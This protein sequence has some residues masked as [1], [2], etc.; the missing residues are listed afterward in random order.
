MVVKSVQVESSLKRRGNLRKGGS[1]EREREIRM[2]T[3]KE[4]SVGG[5]LPL[6]TQEDI[7]RV[8]DRKP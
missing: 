7:R 6:R 4:L 3:S 8:L 2:A 5:A 1:N